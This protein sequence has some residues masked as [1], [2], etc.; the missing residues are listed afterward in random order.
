[1]VT[2]A[3]VRR[4]SELPVPAW[5]Y[6]AASITVDRMSRDFFHWDHLRVFM[7]VVDVGS[8]SAAAARLGES[9]PTIAR[10]VQELEKILNTELLKRSP[11]GVEPTEAGRIAMKQAL[12]MAEAAEEVRD[13]ASGKRAEIEGK[14]KLVTGDGLGPYWIAPR[15]KQFT[16]EF[17]RVQ[18][19]ML[20]QRDP[21]DLINGEADIAIQFTEPK[22]HEV[23]AHRLGTLHYIG[24]ASAEYLNDHD[25][26]TSV[27]EYYK[28]HCILYDGYV[29][30][31]E[32]WAPRVSEL[33]KMTEFAFITNSASSMIEACRTGGGIAL[34]PTYLKQVFPDLVP[35]NPPEVAPIQF[36][37]T[38]TERVRR[39]PI[40]Q[41]M[42]DWLMSLF[43]ETTAP[44]F[45][46]AYIHPDEIAS[47]LRAE[48]ESLRQKENV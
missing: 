12:L 17:P 4:A 24:F 44:W 33:R 5:Q 8:M 43:D 2:G 28:H 48:R 46:S 29:N 20:V 11:R 45:R 35:L 42:I 22:R 6:S 10:K 13:K 23:I 21:P 9:P 26:P 36:W 32:R 14:I 7:T 40:G 18:V 15:L 31:V 30:Q 34:L 3:K 1:M 19:T 41:V 16:T 27:F 39:Q 37:L 47:V 38:Y 25:M